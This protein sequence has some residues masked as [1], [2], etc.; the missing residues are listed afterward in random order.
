MTEVQSYL[1]DFNRVSTFFD[2]WNNKFSVSDM[3]GSNKFEVVVSSYSPN[4]INECLNANGT[5]NTSV[6][7][8]TYSQN[9][10]LTWAND[11]IKVAFDVTFNFGTSIVP[12]KSLFIKHKSIGYVM[13]Y[14][15][16]M[17]TFN[18][19][20]QLVLDADTVLWSIE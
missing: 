8:G 6:V 2:E 1:F 12:L 11:T 17:A 4:N 7:T 20:N 5:L 18:V 3:D 19:T 14:S 13:G 10:P 15:I 16:F 9:L